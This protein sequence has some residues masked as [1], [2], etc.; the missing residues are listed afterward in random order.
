MKLKSAEWTWVHCVASY[1]AQVHVIMN[2]LITPMITDMISI[3]KQNV[4]PAYPLL[5]RRRWLSLRVK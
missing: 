5:I 2:A 1:L 4:I 3:G